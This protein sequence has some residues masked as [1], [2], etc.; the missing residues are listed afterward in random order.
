MMS[1]L[2]L[3]QVTKSYLTQQLPAVD[4]LS[5]ELEK[6]EIL[7]L[8]GP[9]GCGK[10]TTLRLIAGFE[11]PDAGVVEIG[12]RIMANGSMSVPPEQR[13][14]GVVF[15]EYTLFPHL[16]V[17]EN[18]LFGLRHL[19]FQERRQRRREMLEMVGL[20]SFAERYPHEL[21]G[22][23]Q[24][25]VALARALAPR[26]ALLLL[27]EPFSNL[28]ADLRSQMLQDVSIILRDLETTAVF[29]TH[30]HEEAFM[31]ADR[32]GVLNGGCLEQLGSPEEIYQQPRTRFVARFVGRANFLTGLVVAAGIE[33]DIG[34][35]PKTLGLTEGSTVEVM[36]RPHQLELRPHA[37]GNCVVVSRRFRGADALVIVRLPSGATLDTYQPST[38]RFRTGE[39]VTVHARSCHGIV[40]SK[41]EA[42]QEGVKHEHVDRDIIPS[43]FG[44]ISAPVVPSSTDQHYRSDARRS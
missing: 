3:K 36:I 31:V 27:D 12:G 26:P 23:Q 25:R 39:R 1:L 5:F 21:S 35:F 41:A 16:T 42:R 7:A 43:Q 9:S 38:C 10:T 29:V 2:S 24:Q 8:L 17:D 22:G 30:D 34:I 14:I 20:G 32:V 37:A 19:A 33:T 18:V 40:F 4:R 13:G 6:G 15:Q 44:G 11:Q 28:D